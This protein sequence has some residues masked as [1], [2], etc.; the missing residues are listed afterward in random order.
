MGASDS[1]P[2]T[3]AGLSNE[4]RRLVAGARTSLTDSLQF[5]IENE[6]SQ[7]T[8]QL[9]RSTLDDLETA[10]TNGAPVPYLNGLQTDIR[11][12][13]SLAL[14]RGGLLRGFKFSRFF[15][16]APD[17]DWGRPGLREA[18][19]DDEFTKGL[20]D[21]LRRLERSLELTL[22]SALP[23]PEVQKELNIVRDLTSHFY[24]NHS[25][26]SSEVSADSLSYLKAAAVLWI[27]D[28]EK[29]RSTEPVSRVRD[30]IDSKI[31]EVA[32]HF[33]S[34]PYN[35]IKLPVALSDYLAR[36]KNAD[37]SS[38]IAGRQHADV[39]R[40]LENLDPRLRDRWNGAWQALQSENSDAVSQAANSMVETLDQVI[41]K[42]CGD[43]I[44]KDYL[45]Q[46]FPER[47]DMIE[48]LRNLVSANKSDLHRVKHH[49]VNQE[50]HLVE[51]LMQAAELVIRI[52]LRDEVGRE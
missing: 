25:L 3:A 23:L 32:A 33:Q 30:A 12:D 49:P 2:R 39:E 47:T 20:H 50:V 40:L 42:L 41:K 19:F 14:A 6:K 5:V 37:D 44:F 26:N 7:V 45:A 35:R 15:L 8:M 17:R 18:R 24:R 52:L 10:I 29:S 28:L 9:D 46:H 11:F 21:R 51:D 34:R 4:V 16:E 38:V 36:D 27:L 48:A 13:L 43:T 1:Y 22:K 31:F